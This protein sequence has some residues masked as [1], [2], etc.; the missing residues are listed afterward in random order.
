MDST[1][2][3]V[4]LN[5]N[6]LAKLAI[7]PVIIF[8]LPSYNGSLQIDMTTSSAISIKWTAWDNTTDEGD[9]P[10]IGYIIHHR[11]SNAETDDWK[12][13]LIHTT[14]SGTVSGLLWDTNYTFAVSAVRPGGG[15]KG[16]IGMQRIST[17]T[18]CGRPKVGAGI[19]GGVGAA[20]CTIVLVVIITIIFR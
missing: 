10:V 8:R 9:G 19:G 15:G 2:T 7:L 11:L 20:I 6:E 12:Q 16:P 3:C 13:S 5:A 1:Y 18:L 17:K 4:I 14:L